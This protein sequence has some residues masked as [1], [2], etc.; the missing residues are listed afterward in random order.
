MTL[1]LVTV[2]SDLDG[3]IVESVAHMF[4]FSIIDPYLFHLCR[5]EVSI[6]FSHKSKK[7]AML[8]ELHDCQLSK[9]LTLSVVEKA[10]TQAWA[11][12]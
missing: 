12:R 7:P 9:E 2:S 11:P 5:E 10:T 1:A 3:V 6:T 8:L 4:D